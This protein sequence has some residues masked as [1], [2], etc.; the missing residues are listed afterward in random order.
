MLILPKRLVVNG[1]VSNYA[2]AVN[3]TWFNDANH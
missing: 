2:L 1:N 3:S